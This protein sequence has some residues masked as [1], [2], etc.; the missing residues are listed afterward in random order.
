MS[1]GD[2]RPLGGKGNY[3]IPESE[4]PE[5]QVE[6]VKGPLETRI[7]SKVWKTRTEAFTELAA[8]FRT[9]P[10][11]PFD[12]FLPSFPKYLGDAH[13][14]AQEQVMDAFAAALEKRPDVVISMAPDCVRALI[15]K[16]L[17]SAKTTN[18]AAAGNLLLLLFENFSSGF[19]DFTE[20]VISTLDNKNVKVQAAG[21]SA[22]TL[23][24]KDFGPANFQVKMLLVPM[25]KL[26]ASTNP[27][28]RVE[29]MNFFKEAYR[30]LRDAIKPTIDRLKK[31]QQE[32]LTKSFEEITDFPQPTR[33]NK[34]QKPV[35]AKSAAGP[36]IDAYDLADAKDIFGKYGANWVERVLAMEKWVEKKEAMEELNR[37]ADTP[38]LA[39]RSPQ[40]LVTLVKR[41][42]VDNNMNVQLQAIKLAGLL[43]RGQR[44]Y[45]EPFAKQLFPLLLLKLKDKKG[46]VVQESQT[47][48]DSMLKSA[49]FEDFMEDVSKLLEDKAPHAKINAMNL[50][51][52]VGPTLPPRVKAR[53]GRDLAV[54][55]KKN[56][57]D[58]NSDVREA[59]L[60][61]LGI[62]KA[63]V[64]ADGVM[65]VV[66]DLPA[67]K[68]Q[69]VN[70]IAQELGEETTEPG[71]PSSTR[72]VEEEIL[73]PAP[74]SRPKKAELIV[75]EEEV[76]EV[77]IERKP[78]AR[79]PPPKRP[80]TAK[81]EESK[82]PSGGKSAGAA[83]AQGDDDGG[84]AI[85]PE[86]AEQR[87]TG[88]VP[89]SIM[90]G[91]NQT[92]WKEKQSALQELTAWIS[93]NIDRATEQSE[94]LARH[95]RVK[96]K[97]WKENNFNV[98][99]A[100]FEAFLVLTQ[101]C[102]LTKRGAAMVLNAAALD[103]LS[104]GKVV[105]AYLQVMSAVSESLSPRFVTS[106]I[107]KGTHDSGKPKVIVES[108]SAMSKLLVEFGA[109]TMNVKD[110][111]DYGKNCISNTNPTIKKGGQGLLVTLY[112]FMGESLIP[113]LTDVKEATMKVLQAEFATTEIRKNTAFK[114]V[115][116]E[117][118]KS[119]D[120][121]KALDDAIPRN[122]ISNQ[123]TSKMLAA[124]SDSN[125][126]VRKE[127][128][129]AIEE[130]LTASGM[131][132]LPTGL[133]DV[134]K[135]LKGRLADPNKSLCR[136][137]MSLVGK[138]AE[139][140]G[141]ECKQ[142]NRSLVPGLLGNLADK[143]SL[144]RQDA[145]AAI[146]K[147]AKEA[148]P[149]SI[150]QFSAA[151]LQ[152][153]NPEL[154]SELINWLLAHK[155]NLRNCELEPFIPSLLMCLQDRVAGIRNGGELLFAEVIGMVGFDAVTPHLKDIKPA[156]I[157]TLKPIIDKYRT[158]SAVE[159]PP[160]PAATPS[161]KE[162]KSTGRVVKASSTRS[163]ADPSQD[164]PP[165]SKVR[166]A[167]VS[168]DIA[169]LSGGKKEKRL[170]Q[171]LR[172]KW[173]VE[174]L[175]LDYV[176][177][178]NEQLRVC[179]S[180]DLYAKMSAADFKKQVEALTHLTSFL[181][182]NRPMFIENLDLIIK[183][184]FV[185]MMDTTINTQVMKG[186]LELSAAMIAAFEEDHYMFHQVE[187][188]IFLMIMCD[189]SGHNN[190]TFRTQI[191]GI[192]HSCTKICAPAKVFNCVLQGVNSKNN[193]SKVECLEELGALVL[194]F[195]TTV[196]QPRDIKAIAKLV[197]HNDGSVR[198]AAVGAIAEVYKHLEDR[199][200]GLIG[201]INDKAKEMIEQRFKMLNG[202]N[203]MNKTVPAKTQSRPEASTPRKAAKI[204]EPA[205]V[206]TTEPSDDEIPPVT[207]IKPSNSD[208]KIPDI[209]YHPEELGR[210]DTLLYQDF[211]KLIPD[212]EPAHPNVLTSH[213]H[214]LLN[215]DMSAQVDSLVYINDELLP[216]VEIYL[217]D[218]REKGSQFLDAITRVMIQTFD[219]P[220]IEV[221]IRF[222]K[223]FLSVVHKI[224]SSKPIMI[225]VDEKTLYQLS[226]Q[227]LRDLL[228]ENLDKLGER[229]EG[230]L[231]LKTL[232]GTMLR[233]LENCQPTLVFVVLIRLLTR[234]RND[235]TIPK[236]SG[237]I[238]RCLLKLTKILGNLKGDLHVNRL[239]LAMHEYLIQHRNV[240]A[241]DEIGN[242]TIKTILNELVKLE[243][244]RIWE[245]YESVRRHDV[246]D[247]CLERW[248]RM[249]SSTLGPAP[250][251]YQRMRS[252]PRAAGLPQ[253]L[254][255]ISSKLKAAE[256]YDDG[257]RLLY[258]YTERNPATE[259]KFLPSDLQ[260]RVDE[261]IQ[262]LRVRAH[263]SKAPSRFSLEAARAE[264]K[265]E[266]L[267][268]KQID[269]SRPVESPKTTTIPA[270][271]AFRTPPMAP[272]P[273]QSPR[274]PNLDT[275]PRAGI[276]NQEPEQATSF[277]IQDFQDRLAMMKKRYGLVNS[278][279][280]GPPTAS[281]SDLKTKVNSLLAPE[282]KTL[283]SDMKSRL[284]SLKKP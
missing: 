15:E 177:R 238:I 124:L 202:G 36:R 75:L 242:K 209:E 192:M 67:A 163:L 189:K 45:F 83:S 194:D 216:K 233:I 135:G 24:L 3:E 112:S 160:P 81:P 87:L 253:E 7:E 174:E 92:A 256:T 219:K 172:C 25:E 136:Q 161:K 156:I 138:F 263:E 187:V 170:E 230:E 4:L 116:G 86:E 70:E 113:L 66:G 203:A 17:T 40:E 18:K 261:D 196:Y 246:Q 245:A 6:E 52:R 37:E 151:T 191:R 271:E 204:P 41:L 227:V 145:I 186:I 118:S 185:K 167:N 272:P 107:M 119:T 182:T 68:L 14:G 109:H 142:F 110:I 137:S 217:D 148:G 195:G 143:Q 22:V 232:N 159:E 31:A 188:D 165:T 267:S 198:L 46:P 69:K 104:E 114:V 78:P 179:V 77:P 264:L 205:R 184:M 249:M 140:L 153:E 158:Q 43:A 47:A 250:I 2:D 154:R 251:S 183:W 111:I 234:Y 181:T 259:L 200:W 141:S 130:I 169:L 201:E 63:K 12:Q 102:S 51:D 237:L 71:T 89:D 171:E 221:Q 164:L 95:I 168:E 178:M 117:E 56:L 11:P 115:K 149:E 190:A 231:M 79:K 131:R 19:E 27:A 133:T 235:Q 28:V 146:D 247:E 175:R 208:S 207:P 80:A 100:A 265:S 120:P 23:I 241:S 236:M 60:K 276:E 126:K 262:R 59:M 257:I 243:G 44:R 13:P 54:M 64:S 166:S 254:L 105:E 229:G 270:Q 277:R 215:Q 57:N 5:T 50:I 279:D 240:S 99:K 252:P 73:P 248:I 127:T 222:A 106:M 280:S 173:S 244:E 269:Y 65:A 53:I 134:I 155:E 39:E 278:G 223:Y 206:V 283:L 49:D 74:P 180:P 48:L 211:D 144:L 29:V 228:I 273:S 212:I 282:S 101:Q 62:L 84:A 218:F 34:G 258:A 274:V 1:A 76:K 129:D 21:A 152:Q 88:L 103:K 8:L 197:S 281:V 210:P 26:A 139:A 284:D 225:S 226:E 220:V 93:S 94:A 42:L 61:S 150:I 32:E 55:V 98:V 121:R 224:C 239:L 199:I 260:R 58:S 162:G 90:T 255:E 91:L 10:D 85:T 30:W 9:A 96:C 122:N 268:T 128:M 213:I 38:K 132:I 82:A 72:V 147:W 123:I 176:E 157:N 16:G 97:D 266:Q 108:C 193:R 125:W 275:P 33:L 35:A 214:T 20:A